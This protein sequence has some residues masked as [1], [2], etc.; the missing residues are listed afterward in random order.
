[1]TKLSRFQKN[2][3]DFTFYLLMMCEKLTVKDLIL[4]DK[5]CPFT[6]NFTFLKK[7]ETDLA[8]LID[9]DELLLFNQSLSSGTQIKKLIYDKYDEL[10]GKKKGSREKNKD[11]NLNIFLRDKYMEL[12][13]DFPISKLEFIRYVSKIIFF[14]LITFIIVF[15]IGFQQ[16]IQDSSMLMIF[17]SIFLFQLFCL[18]L[19]ISYSKTIKKK[20]PKYLQ[21]KR[22]F[23]IS[24]CYDK[25]C[26]SKEILEQILFKNYPFERLE[27]NRLYR[28]IIKISPKM[29]YVF[30]VMIEKSYWH[31]D[32]T[33][34]IQTGKCTRQLIAKLAGDADLGINS[35]NSWHDILK[36]LMLLEEP[37]YNY[38]KSKDDKTWN[39]VKELI[40]EELK[41]HPE[42]S[43]PTN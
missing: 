37:L 12:S 20:G 6:E 13:S 16:I 9:D 28:K 17:I 30:K 5:N 22:K 18:Y 43:P 7:I 19:W 41:K 14:F 36:T 42:F 24:F 3:N 25:L 39:K 1:M 29:K 33:I 23:S 40:I 26:K 2:F 32:G 8:D 21:F 38:Q 34:I 27:E 35:D 4:Y 31:Y 10:L 11:K 15:F